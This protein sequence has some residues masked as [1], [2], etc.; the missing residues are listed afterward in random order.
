[1]KVPAIFNPDWLNKRDRLG[2]RRRDIIKSLLKSI[3][4]DFLTFN[5]PH[6]AA[7]IAFWGLFSMFP[8]VLA[9]IIITGDFLSYDAFIERVGN[10]IPVSRDFITDT[11]INI[12]ND[13]PYTG[14]AA[15]IGLVWASLAVFSATRKG[16]NAAWAI[17]RPR[18]FM[19]ERVIDFSLMLGSWLIF[20][21]SISI[22]PIIEFSR[23]TS[24]TDTADAWS[25][26]WFLLGW[27][28]PLLLTFVSFA[29]LYRYIPNTRVHWKD[30]WP[31]AAIAAVS[32]EA[33]RHGF[34]WYIAHISIYNLVYGTAATMVVLLAWAYF[35]GVILLFGA[36]VSSRLNKL[37][38]KRQQMDDNG[39]GS[40]QIIVDMLVYTKTENG[41]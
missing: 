39:D 8:M 24:G 17:F 29:T 33:L 20:T 25:G 7:S 5:V 36:V 9:V 2:Q 32:F 35:S 21:L 34:V 1:M 13:W 40:G 3:V 14:T 41:G 38:R 16:I 11:L 10:A 26:T 22:T 18:S 31:G 6:M 15:V 27:G 37:R 12:S 23:S 28:L 4:H 30:V 19:R